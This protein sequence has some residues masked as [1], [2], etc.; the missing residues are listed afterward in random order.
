VSEQRQPRVLHI[1]K[2][3]PPVPGGIETYLGDLLRVSRRHGLAVGAVVHGKKGY[4]DPN[5]ADF[6]G[7]KIYTVPTY[8]QVLYAPVAPMFPWVLRRAIKEFKPDILH[9]HVPNPSAFWALFIPEARKIPWVLQ[10]QADV[11]GEELPYVFRIFA[12]FYRLFETKLLRLSCRVYVSSESYLGSSKSLAGIR[13]KVVILPLAVDPDRLRHPVSP[14][15]GNH[16]MVAW[17]GNDCDV[18]LLSVG[19]LTYYKGFEVLIRAVKNAPKVGIVIVGEGHLAERLARLVSDLDLDDQVKLVGYQPDDVVRE[20]MVSADYFCLPSIDR[21]E[22]FGL[23]LLE[24]YFLG[25][26]LIVS[27]IPGSGAAEVARQLGGSRLFPPGD[28]AA[29]QRILSVLVPFTARDEE[30]RRAEHMS[31]L[32]ARF[33]LNPNSIIDCYEGLA[34]R[35]ISRLKANMP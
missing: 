33:R 13:N 7:A 26:R 5:P 18:R 14:H 21:S 20:L 25:C 12:M 10:W 22:S 9:M 29:L 23:V 3:L 15:N 27:D 1:G 6:G 2:Y 31:I 28:I 8:G 24:A 34:S 11:D 16:N 35:E 30:S 4:P 19:R 17:W 32:P